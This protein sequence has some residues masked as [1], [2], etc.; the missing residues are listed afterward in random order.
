VKPLTFIRCADKDVA[1]YLRFHIE[2]TYIL[3]W[4]LE[5]D[6]ILYFLT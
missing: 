6:I 3:A 4:C 1:I 2:N 5:A